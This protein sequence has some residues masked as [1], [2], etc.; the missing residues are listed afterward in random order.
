[1]LLKNLWENM[2]AINSVRSKSTR[3]WRLHGH[4]L[5][6]RPWPRV[7]ALVDDLAAP[8]GGLAMGGHPYR[9]LGLAA[10]L[11]RGQFA[12]GIAFVAD[13]CKNS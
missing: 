12:V 5:C 3:R 2:A 8:A 4:R 7:A 10:P 9:R 6:K 11:A 13:R 1:M